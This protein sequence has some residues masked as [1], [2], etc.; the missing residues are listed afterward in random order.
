MY[1]NHTSEIRNPKSN[2]PSVYFAQ[3]LKNRSN[4]TDLLGK[5]TDFHGV[6][7][8]VNKLFNVN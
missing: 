6:L 7:H 3:N 2:D 5:G 1:R 4:L 8:K